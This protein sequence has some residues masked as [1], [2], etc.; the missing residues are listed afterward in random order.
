MSDKPLILV[1]DDEKDIAENISEFLLSTEKYE[2]LI[3]NSAVEALKI[4]NKNKGFLGLSN[5]V[6]LIFLD[7]KMPEMSGLEFLAKLREDYPED[8]IGV[9][10][11]T[12]WEDEEKWKKAR[13]GGAAGYLNKPFKGDQLLSL[14]DRFFAGKDLW[15]V[16]QT[17]WELLSK[18]TQAKVNKKP[19]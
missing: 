13:D 3:S 11:L 10:M 4:V 6:R 16:E 14:A 15:M 1:V 18:E 8:K 12:A 5:K 9:I 17:K 7:I 2:T 19:D